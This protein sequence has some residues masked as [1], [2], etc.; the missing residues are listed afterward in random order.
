M[1]L[2]SIESLL[3]LTHKCIHSLSW[4]E[5][6]CVE[7]LF[8]ASSRQTRTVYHI[9]TQYSSTVQDVV[10]LFP[11]QP[12]LWPW[13]PTLLL[14]K[15]LLMHF[16]LPDLMCTIL[17]NRL[18]LIWA[19]VQ[20]WGN[21]A[22]LF[23]IVRAENPRVAM[24]WAQDWVMI[25]SVRPNKGDRCVK[26]ENQWLPVGICFSVRPLAVVLWPKWSLLH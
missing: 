21:C 2:H 26:L 25:D 11:P 10:P 4:L 5:E 1:C 16:F 3:A 19:L 22:V 18:N 7:S 20:Q 12:W 8:C 24:W 6:S 13:A 14:P 9:L 17:T 15:C 23:Y